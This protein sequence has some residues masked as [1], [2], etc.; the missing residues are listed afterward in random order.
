MGRG[1]GVAEIELV[2]IHPVEE[3]RPVPAAVVPLGQVDELGESSPGLDLLEG[4]DGGE[5]RVVVPPLDV[6]EV[7]LEGLGR[8]RRVAADHPDRVDGLLVL[9]LAQ[10][11]RSRRAGKP[12]PTSWETRKRTFLY[13]SSSKFAEDVGLADA[14]PVEDLQGEVRAGREA[15]GQHD[16]AV[17]GQVEPGVAGRHPVDLVVLEGQAELPLEERVGDLELADVEVEVGAEEVVEHDEGVL[18]AG[19]LA[20]LAEEEIEVVGDVL[21]DLAAREELQEVGRGEIRPGGCRRCCR[22][23]SLPAGGRWGRPGGGTGESSPVSTVVAGRFLV[24]DDEAVRRR[25]PRRRA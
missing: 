21:G 6:L 12:G 14:R 17:V 25:T 10:D 19:D 22:S 4:Q 1:R 2:G 8:E 7:E 11:S 24:L 18:D 9:L 16:A 13:L 5:E 20:P 23:G 15:V 3:P